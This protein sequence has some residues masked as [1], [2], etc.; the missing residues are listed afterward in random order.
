MGK[1]LLDIYEAAGKEGGLAVQMRLAMLTGMAG[2][3]AG[4]A[5]DTAELVKKFTDAYKEITGKNCPVY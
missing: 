4:N 3:Q 1:K 2:P 5:T